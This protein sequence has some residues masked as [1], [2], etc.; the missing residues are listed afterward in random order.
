MKKYS[1]IFT[2]MGYWQVTNMYEDFLQAEEARKQHG[3]AWIISLEVLGNV[4]ARRRLHSAKYG[5]EHPEKEKCRYIVIF[6]GTGVQNYW[7]A[8]DGY[9]DIKQADEAMTSFVQNGNAA[10]I[11]SLADLGSWMAPTL[12]SITLVEAEAEAEAK[13]GPTLFD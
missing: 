6:K 3:R 5:L 9:E 8:T 13:D 11:I 1:V 4:I 10:Y 12:Y 2:E 7:Q